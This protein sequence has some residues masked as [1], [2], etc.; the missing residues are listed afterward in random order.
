MNMSLR[1]VRQC[2]AAVLERRHYTDWRKFQELKWQTR[3]ICHMVA[4]TVEVA[5][6]H[7]NELLKYAST[8]GDPPDEDQAVTDEDELDRAR[9]EHG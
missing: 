4:A 9:K 7:E 3:E 6:G 5:E 2:A 1:R 8:I